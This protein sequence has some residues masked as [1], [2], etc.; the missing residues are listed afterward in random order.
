MKFDFG[1]RCAR[2]KLLVAALLGIAVCASGCTYFAEQPEVYPDKFAPQ[3]SDRAWIPRS[4]QYTI[5]AQARP[6][7]TLPEPH[8]ASTGNTY[9]LPALIDIALTNNP[10][11]RVTWDQARAS[12]DACGV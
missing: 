12:A 10:D 1:M 5:P 2:Q 6:P 11:T 8:P 7:S 3:D 9:D 4:N